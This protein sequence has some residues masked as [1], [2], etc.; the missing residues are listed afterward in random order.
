M[1]ESIHCYKL[2]NNWINKI[3]KRLLILLPIGL[4]ANLVLS[5]VLTD[6]Q[7]FIILNRLSVFQWV[8]CFMLSVIPWFTHLLRMKIWLWFLGENIKIRDIFSIAIGTELGAGISPTAMGGGVLKASMLMQHGIKPGTAISLTLLGSIEDHAFFLIAVPVAFILSASEAHDAIFSIFERATIPDMRLIFSGLAVLIL[9]VSSIR[10]ILKRFFPSLVISDKLKKT[11]RQMLSDIKSVYVMIGRGGKRFF[12]LALLVTAV[13]WVAR[14][15]IIVVLLRGLGF[16]LDPIQCFL[17]QWII[18]VFSLVVPTPGA[19]GGAEA[20]FYVIFGILLPDSVI[21]LVTPM[22][23]FLTYYFQLGF[24]ALL[25]TFLTFAI[26]KKK[27]HG[28]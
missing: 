7:I 8:L 16:E 9:A 12:L 22:W 5:Y 24:G 19:S 13:H 15:S 18:A 3:V 11:F 23:R 10:L 2:E 14:Y 25:Y 21:G 20:S 4:L 26:L 1:D 17:L 28:L 6:S 27:K